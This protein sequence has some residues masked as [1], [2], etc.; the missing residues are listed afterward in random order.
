MSS[1]SYTQL[2]KT[3]KGNEIPSAPFI[4]VKVTSA[5]IDCNEFLECDALLDTGSSLT[6]FPRSL[7]V[8]HICKFSAGE[9]EKAYG[10]GGGEVIAIPY[11]ANIRLGGQ[12]YANVKVWG[13]VH[14]KLSEADEI[15]IIGRDFM[16]R[17]RIEFDGINSAITVNSNPCPLKNCPLKSC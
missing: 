2:G 17:L 15:P 7:I 12:F 9:T 6:L 11:K 16:K 5:D 3:L 14:D 1:Y 8:P 4:K 10:V 13:Y